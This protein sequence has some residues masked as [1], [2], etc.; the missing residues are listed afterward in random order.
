M[1]ELKYHQQATGS[2]AGYWVVCTAQ[3]Q[4]RLGGE[5]ITP[6]EATF[7]NAEQY[8][9]EQ[10]VLE[11]EYTTPTLAPTFNN[12]PE[13]EVIAVVDEVAEML[14]DNSISPETLDLYTYEIDIDGVPTE[15]S[16]KSVGERGDIHESYDGSSYKSYSYVV[17]VPGK[18]FDVAIFVTDDGKYIV[19]NAETDYHQVEITT[20]EPS[21]LDRINSSVDLYNYYLTKA[22]ETLS[23]KETIEYAM[24]EMKDH[25][26][27]WETFKEVWGTDAETYQLH[28]QRFEY[29]EEYIYEP[30]D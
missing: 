21:F 11:A 2:K 5:H 4:C 3:Q 25:P 20:N 14:S 15:Y 10:A 27:Q 7:R 12:V 1:S 8:A 16:F 29:V 18:Q 24:R 9:R 23:K 30:E 26:E 22:P 13:Y 28:K 6:G 17:D 19:Q